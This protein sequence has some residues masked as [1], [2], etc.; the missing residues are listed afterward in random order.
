[1]GAPKQVNK[2]S[3]QFESPAFEGV[4]RAQ[5][6]NARLLHVNLV[7]SW[8]RDLADSESYADNAKAKEAGL[9]K[10]DLYITKTTD[11]MSGVTTAALKIVID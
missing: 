11:G 9:K 7:I 2:L 5:T 1:M 8:L 3:Q 6:G 10:G 4:T